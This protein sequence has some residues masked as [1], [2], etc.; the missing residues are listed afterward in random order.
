MWGAMVPLPLTQRGTGSSRH[1]EQVWHAWALGLA[2][3][4]SSHGAVPISWQPLGVWGTFMES[5]QPSV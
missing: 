4:L 1:E 2:G 5:G 3:S